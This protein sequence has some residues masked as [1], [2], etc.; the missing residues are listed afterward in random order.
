MRKI[1]LIVLLLSL[2]PCYGLAEYAQTHQDA[3]AIV[4]ASFNYMREKTSVS[5]IDMLIY[6]PDWKRRMRIKAW[7]KGQD[8]SIFWIIMPPKDKGN[9]TLKK[10]REMWIY[11]PKVNRVIKLPPSMIP[12]LDGVGF[13]QR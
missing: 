2:L 10:N 8:Q 5:T 7:T 12:G 3:H 13:F 1:I 6:R 9:G 4:E 11:N